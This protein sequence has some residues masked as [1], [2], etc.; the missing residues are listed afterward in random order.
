[1]RTVFGTVPLAGAKD[2]RRFASRTVLPLG[3]IDDEHR[4][5]FIDFG[6]T[7][8][9]SPRDGL[10]KVKNA[11]YPPARRPF[12]HIVSV[13]E[14]AGSFAVCRSSGKSPGTK[15][16]KTEVCEHFHDARKRST[17]SLQP[18]ECDRRF[19]SCFS[20]LLTVSLRFGDRNRGHVDDAA[21][22]HRRR[23]D[24]GGLGGADQDRADR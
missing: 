9:F 11:R 8:L 20:G 4:L 18:Q 13:P 15:A 10:V 22:R 21:R 17:I 19:G 14:I 16:C 3:S 12:G 7:L 24:M 5:P 23:Q 6:Q 2:S 1:L